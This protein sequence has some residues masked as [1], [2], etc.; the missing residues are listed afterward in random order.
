MKTNQQMDVLY[1][2]VREE[3]LDADE[4]WVDKDSGG[5]GHEA[6]AVLETKELEP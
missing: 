6:V 5:Y 1:Q 3:H 4:E 2:E